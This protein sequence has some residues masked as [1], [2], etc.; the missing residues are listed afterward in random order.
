MSSTRSRR[1]S[2]RVP[3][4]EVPRSS[5]SPEPT[6]AAAT[7]SSPAPSRSAPPPARSV[8]PPPPND[9]IDGARTTDPGSTLD[10]AELQAAEI[11]SDDD[12]G[13]PVDGETPAGDLEDERT[14]LLRDAPDDA[15][16]SGRTMTFV[17][18]HDAR[19]ASTVPG[20]PPPTAL[21]RAEGASSGLGLE[22]PPLDDERATS[23]MAA[24]AATTSPG[25]DAPEAEA[26]SRVL[27]VTSEVAPAAAE[28]S[29]EPP[30]QPSVVVSTSIVMVRT[31]A[32]GVGS[33]TSITTAQE[34]ASMPPM[35]EPAFEI[36]ESE[37]DVEDAR[38]SKVDEKP[39]E[40]VEELDELDVEPDAKTPRSAPPPPPAGGPPPPPARPPPP[41]KVPAV[42]AAAPP[43]PPV[44]TIEDTGK[45]SR[46]KWWEE[47]FNDDYFRTVPLPQPKTV[48]AQATFI[49]ARLGLRPGSAILD[50]GCGLGLHAVELTKLGYTVVGLDLSLPMLSRAADEAQDHGLKINFIQGDMREMQF[51]SMFDA[52]ISWGTTFGY[53]DDDQNRQVVER[54]HRALKPG[55]LL[56]LD[57]VNRDYVVRSTPNSAW[58]QGDG[59]VV[60]EETTTNYINS[61]LT[62]KRQVMLDDGR[63]NET[64]YTI[65][66]YSLHELGQI[67]HQRGFRVVEVSGREATPAV[68]FGADSPRMI[69]VAERR[70]DVPSSGGS[71]PSRRPEERSSGDSQQ[72]QVPRDEPKAEAKASDKPDKEP[73][74]DGEPEGEPPK[75]S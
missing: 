57:V 72:I 44:P 31:I 74:P 51:E 65:R 24:F 29:A 15:I 28:P 5:T 25:D 58:F 56:L 43:A 55:G 9:A 12:L 71:T 60:M 27:E 11:W 69:I 33:S 67:L 17:E 6:A 7:P 47:F 52:V 22:E 62:V 38:D 73:K 46:R 26:P 13:K 39:E 40:R 42:P 49:A 70:V 23:E 34:R 8:P 41:P 35:S 36:S 61:R 54:L 66:L 16:A 19:E 63:Q 37:L 18:P 30:S 1:R 32:I 2:L 64:L 53:F 45:R 10:S 75:S 21:D 3:L 48:A 50:V 4:D 20:G 14:T 68:F 59:C